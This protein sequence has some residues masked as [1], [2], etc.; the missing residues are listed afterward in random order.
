[1]NIDRSEIQLIVFYWLP[2]FSGSFVLLISAYLGHV[3][4][5]HRWFS[6]KLGSIESWVTG[7][8]TPAFGV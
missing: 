4:V 5:M 8:T 6:W 3:E 2:F 1:M 7:K